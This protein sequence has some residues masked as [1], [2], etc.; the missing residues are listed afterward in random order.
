MRSRPTA[1]GGVLPGA[2]GVDHRGHRDTGERA[3]SASVTLPEISA[4]TSVPALLARIFVDR[5]Q[6]VRARQHRGCVG[7]IVPV[8]LAA[9]SDVLP[10]G[11]GGGRGDDDLAGRER[12]GSDWP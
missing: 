8:T 6:V 5:R 7:T 9:N 1:V 12:T 10:D 4:E 3:A 2:V 11:I